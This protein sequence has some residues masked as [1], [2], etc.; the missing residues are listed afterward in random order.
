MKDRVSNDIGAKEPL[1]KWESINW[2]LVN[3]QIKNLRQRIYRATQ[4]GQ[5]NKVR[6]LMKLMILSYSNL[7][8]SVGR[9]TQDNQGK[10]RHEVVQRRIIAL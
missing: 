10:V 9:V 1:E 7:L 6:S 5:W 3:K 2:K 8:M 4:N